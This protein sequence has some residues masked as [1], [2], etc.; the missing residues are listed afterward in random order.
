VTE[1]LG[2]P[3]E[4][5]DRFLSWTTQVEEATRAA[6]PEAAMDVFGHLAGYLN[7][8]IARQSAEG[9]T[10]TILA[11]L[12]DAQVDGR[13]LNDLEVLVFF[14]LLAFAGHDT[15]R[16]TVSSGLLALMQH[17]QALA[18]LRRD[19][20]LTPAAVEEILRWTSV[21]QWF[22]RTAMCDTEL[23]GQRIA[24]GDRVALWYTSASR[25]EKVFEEPD[26]FDIHRA[27]PDHDAFGGGGRHFCLGAGLGRLDIAVILE[28]TIRRLDGL[29]LDGEVGRIP[30]HWTNALSSL[31]VSFTPGAREAG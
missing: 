4:D 12:R 30:S 28:E 25:D 5:F 8:Q 2:V 7:E 1:L 6:E 10:D 27:R 3:E 11:K 29:R 9:R 14:A 15:S 13:P 23:G 24:A 17:P 26:R 16:N 31:P 19:P 22:S 18:E 21:V 20:S